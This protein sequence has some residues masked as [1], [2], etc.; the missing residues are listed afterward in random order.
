M[1]STEDECLKPCLTNDRLEAHTKKDRLLA[2]C[3]CSFVSREAELEANISENA[4]ALAA[5]Q[6]AIDEHS[7]RAA[8]ADERLAVLEAE[9]ASLSASLSAFQ[10]QSAHQ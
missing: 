2:T 4:T 8:A 1:A 7:L 3:A 10:E 9:K 5:M 6:R